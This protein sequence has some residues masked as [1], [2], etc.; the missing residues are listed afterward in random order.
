LGWLNFSAASIPF[1]RCSAACC[2]VGPRLC[3]SLLARSECFK[4]LVIIRLF[5]VELNW[6]FSEYSLALEFLLEEEQSAPA[7]S[8]GCFQTSMVL[9]SAQLAAATCPSG[10]FIA[11]GLIPG[12]Q[13]C[14]PALG[15]CVNNGYRYVAFAYQVLWPRIDTIFQAQV[16]LS[17]RRFVRL[18]CRP[19]S[20]PRFTRR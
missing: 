5:S 17:Q 16:S 8:L 9:L 7:N 2:S 10:Q 11:N 12:M 15:H 3:L 4:D 19:R 13:I 20:H 6:I 18:A 1:V 14:R